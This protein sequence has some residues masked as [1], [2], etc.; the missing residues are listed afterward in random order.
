MHRFAYTF[1]SSQHGWGRFAAVL[2]CASV[3]AG[4]PSLPSL[5]L[6]EPS[7][8]HVT[9]AH[10]TK[11]PVTKRPSTRTF[12]VQAISGKNIDQIRLILGTP[13]D[14]D[15][16][17]EP[18]ALQ[19]E[20]GIDEWDNSYERGDIS[21]LITFNV[22]TRRIVDFFLSPASG[23]AIITTADKER[24]LDAGNLKLG[25]RRYTVEFVPVHTDEHRFTGVKAIPRT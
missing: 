22:T 3:L 25:D 8:A 6:G 24:I 19:R 1:G 12:D 10:V 2:L 17:I 16:G 7:K 15:P 20:L 14:T 13:L 5:A 21:L 11:A 23:G 9:K 4:G 18:T